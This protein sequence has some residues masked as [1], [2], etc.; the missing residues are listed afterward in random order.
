MTKGLSARKLNIQCLSC[1][2]TVEMVATYEGNL[3]MFQTGHTCTMDLLPV[4]ML[5]KLPVFHK[6]QVT[7][8]MLHVTVTTVTC[9]VTSMTMTSETNIGITIF[10]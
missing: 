1:Q 5:H 6:F 7:S 10:V 8:Y 3:Y 2:T 4:V 9:N